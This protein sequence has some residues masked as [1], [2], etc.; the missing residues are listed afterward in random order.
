MNLEIAASGQSRVEI[1][2]WLFIQ[3]DCPLDKTRLP[4]FE[5][6]FYEPFYQF[7]RQQFLA[8]EME[9]VHEL[10]ADL[11]SLMHISPEHNKDFKRVT[12]PELVG[13]ADSATG[14][15]KK[16]VRPHD[17]FGAVSTEMLFGW[18]PVADYPQM[19]DWWEYVTQ[20]YDWVVL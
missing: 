15:W 5:A 1:Y 16:L 4:C 6:L 2:Q 19:K 11:V 13:L 9:K 3:P 12:A 8:H 17:R 10:G 14:A 18:F 7:M 20:R